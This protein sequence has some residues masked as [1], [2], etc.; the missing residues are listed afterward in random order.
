M[1]RSSRHP[2]VVVLSVYW[3]ALAVGSHWPRLDF[4]RMTGI[5]HDALPLGLDKWL[6]VLGYAGL[7]FLATLANL[8]GGTGRAGGPRR[9]AV[10]VVYAA[11]DELTQGFFA[12]REVGLADF[13]A[14]CAG[15]ALGLASWR[16]L[17]WLFDHDGSFMA[18]ARVVSALTLLSRV[19]GLVRDWLLQFVFGFGGLMD[20]WN[21]AFQVPNLF[22]RLFGEGALA[23]AFVPQYSKLARSDPAGAAA[24]RRRVVRW[25]AVR[26]SA[27]S[28]LGGIVCLGLLWTGWL[29][30]RAVTAAKIT[31][32]TLWYAPMICITAILGAALQS[33]DRFGASSA[34]PILMNLF[35]IASVLL[36]GYALPAE[37]SDVLR[38]ALVAAGLLLSGA[39]Q[40]AWHQAML[41][42]EGGDARPDAIDQAAVDAAM[43]GLLT[44]WLPMVVGIAVFQI[45]SFADTMIA[46]IFS[47]PQGAT[48]TMLGLTAAYPLTI[49]SV[50]VL[51]AAQRLYE[52]PLGVFGVAVATTIFPQLARRSDEPESF[53]RILRQGL[54]LTV[55]IGLPASAGLVLVALPLCKA[56]FYHVGR[57][58]PQDAGRIAWVLI[59]YA[60]AVWAYS[61]NQVLTRA[62]YAQHNSK[63]PMRV[64][65]AMVGLNLAGNL[66]LIWPLGAAGL[67][68]STAICATIQCVI[69][70]ACVRRYV[71]RPV[72]GS[73]LRSWLRTALLT[74]AMALP[75]G[76][77]ASAVDVEQ[78]RWSEV[79]GLLAGCAALGVAVVLLGAKLLKMPELRWL[80]GRGEGGRSDDAVAP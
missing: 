7:A 63:L 72:D 34:S 49:G 76:W 11:L 79:I 67:A 62:F 29:D 57:I 15:L 33:H 17:G 54:R 19:F 43:K 35:M 44:Q 45:N 48:L 52:F 53:G 9:A 1:I 60:P 61:M 13:A 66:L 14:S 38:I 30:E 58:Q 3:L 78:L 77:L 12:G 24:F 16:A 75:V 4:S 70:L 31:A 27:L 42:A 37:T 69:L 71:P 6:H 2:W 20:A 18:H 10:L 25:M 28:A 40:W 47:G 80:L 64:A 26:L 68:W 56:I 36:A 50:S 46:K 23:A 59:G 39:A 22:R 5:G 32:V 74:A 51:G 21:I 8:G 65:T 73:V 55:F 41:P